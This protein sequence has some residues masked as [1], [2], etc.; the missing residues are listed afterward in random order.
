ML[1]KREEGK[2]EA[3][4]CYFPLK[5]ACLIGLLFFCSQRAD[6]MS[7]IAA[8]FIWHAA[9]TTYHS[10]TKRDLTHRSDSAGGA[11]LSLRWISHVCCLVLALLFCKCSPH[12]TQRHAE[13][14]PASFK[15]GARRSPRWRVISTT[16]H[17]VHKQGL[18][19]RREKVLIL[20]E[21]QA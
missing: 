8:T 13:Q 15:P 6:W 19:G 11:W 14:L 4:I 3:V 21:R 1:K 12:V 2:K 7:N 5:K 16:Q 9:T 17:K 20:G 18:C 10:S